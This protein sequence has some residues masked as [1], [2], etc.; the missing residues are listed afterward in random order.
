[1]KKLTR[2]KLEK[3]LELHA[4]DEKV[5]DVGSGNSSYGKFFPNRLTLDYDPLRK[6]D[7]VADACHLPFEDNSYHTIICTEMLEHVIDPKQV[8]REFYRVL[9]TGGKLILTTRF[10]YPFHDAPEDYW[11]FTPSTLKHIFSDFSSVAITAESKEM[12]TIS[13]LLERIILQTKT[14]GGK[15]TKFLLLILSRFFTTL[16]WIVIKSYGNIQKTT[17]VEE[18]M[19]SGYYVVARK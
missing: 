11:R 18:I 12:T 9:D 8:A 10:V 13:I 14:R 19:S 15:F 7:V 16:D 3:F 1:M 5:L 4:T 17:E 6:P 2:Q